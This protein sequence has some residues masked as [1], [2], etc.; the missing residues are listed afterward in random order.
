[1]SLPQRSPTTFSWGLCWSICALSMRAIQHA[2]ECCLKVGTESTGTDRYLKSA[3]T[4]LV[5]YHFITMYKVFRYYCLLYQF[6]IHYNFIVARTVIGQRLAAMNLLS[7]LAI[8]DE[9]STVRLQHNRAFTELLNAA[10]SSYA[11]VTG[12][13]ANIE[14]RGFDS[15]WYVDVLMMVLQMKGHQ[16]FF[17]KLCTVKWAA[18]SA[19]RFFNWAVLLQVINIIVISL[20]LCMQCIQC[21]YCVYPCPILQGLS[22]N[23]HNHAVR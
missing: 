15:S 13:I 20:L 10:S 23:K 4:F 8:S 5:V 6:Q 12:H 16:Y 2:H 7:P 19:Y 14:T 18:Q 17:N 1:M 11:Q 3:N 9:F 22:S 21:L